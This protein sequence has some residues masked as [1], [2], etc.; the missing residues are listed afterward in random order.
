M[1]VKP[2][3]SWLTKEFPYILVLAYGH[4]KRLVFFEFATESRRT[5]R[6]MIRENI[7]ILLVEDHSGDTA[8]FA[9]AVRKVCPQA[10]L[11]TLSTS[12]EAIHYFEGSGKY[13]DRKKFP[14]PDIAFIDLKLPGMSGEQLIK[15]IRGRPEFQ[16][17][18]IAVL[19]GTADARQLSDLYR[20]GADSFLLKSSDINELASNLRE[21]TGY[22]LQ[23][24][25]ITAKPC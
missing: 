9:T 1:T 10:T 8:V 17:L 3:R 6:A 16:K 15:W 19:T 23:R 5:F 22:W 20:W 13:A 14:L 21:L 12:D 7:I 4:F 25:L 18:S 11:V 24:G 2:F